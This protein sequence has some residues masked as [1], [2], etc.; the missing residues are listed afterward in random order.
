M[1]TVA[2]AIAAFCASAIGVTGTVF[3]DGKVETPEIIV[4]ILTV[5]GATVAVYLSPKNAEG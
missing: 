1:A 2:K 3:A 4:G 5:L